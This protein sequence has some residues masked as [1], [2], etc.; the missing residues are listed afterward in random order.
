MLAIQL[1]LRFAFQGK[2][3]SAWIGFAQTQQ[4]SFCIEFSNWLKMHIV[5][6][7]FI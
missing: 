7:I 2:K 3:L 5:P 1:A 6:R 4:P